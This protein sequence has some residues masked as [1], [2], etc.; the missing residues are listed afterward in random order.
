MRILPGEMGQVG[1]CFFNTV[2]LWT[3]PVVIYFPFGSMSL[4]KLANALAHVIDGFVLGGQLT[5][6]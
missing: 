2:N 4:R 1:Y 5:A 6:Q 3:Y